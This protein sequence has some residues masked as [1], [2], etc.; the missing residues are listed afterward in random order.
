METFWRDIWRAQKAEIR[1]LDTKVSFN[2]CF[3]GQN[4]KRNIVL[5]FAGVE[6]LSY[7]LTRC[8]KVEY[9]CMFQ[10]TIA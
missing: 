8:L 2:Q 7:A 6:Y 10:G 9:V 5:Y 3:S 1:I 4:S